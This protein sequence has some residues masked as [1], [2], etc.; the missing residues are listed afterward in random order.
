MNKIRLCSSCL[1]ECPLDP[2]ILKKQRIK[3]IVVVAHQSIHSEGDLSKE[4]PI[5]GPD[6][7]LFNYQKARFK[8][9]WGLVDLIKEKAQQQGY[10]LAFFGDHYELQQ[11]QLTTEFLLA[12]LM[13]YRVGLK[14][15][16]MP[17]WSIEL[18]RKDIAY[19]QKLG[20]LRLKS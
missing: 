18:A 2:V 13:R 15:N 8:K 5:M 11:K 16:E 19:R 12:Y 6:T 9:D 7:L 17:E 20:Q 14:D 4:V 10:S 3:G 1:D